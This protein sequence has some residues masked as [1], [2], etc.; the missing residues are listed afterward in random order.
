MTWQQHT[1][2]ISAGIERLMQAVVHHYQD[3]VRGFKAETGKGPLPTSGRTGL[4]LARKFQ[5]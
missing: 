2:A 3:W 5:L 4:L 1:D